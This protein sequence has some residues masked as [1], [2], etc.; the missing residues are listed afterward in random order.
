MAVGE[1]SFNSRF[2]PLTVAKPM[3]NLTS[4]VFTIWSSLL[5]K[6]AGGISVFNVALVLIFVIEITNKSPRDSLINSLRHM[7][8]DI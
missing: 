6:E 7:V 2:I 1:T 8:L 3:K 5:I 4:S